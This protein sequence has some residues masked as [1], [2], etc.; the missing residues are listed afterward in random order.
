MHLIIITLCQSFRDLCDDGICHLVNVNL[1]G[2]LRVPTVPAF[3]TSDSLGQRN[4]QIIWRGEGK[5]TDNRT[6]NT[7]IVQHHCK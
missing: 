5:V 3:P 1:N 4:M 2:F 7:T 6:D